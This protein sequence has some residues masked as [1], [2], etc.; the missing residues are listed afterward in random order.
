MVSRSPVD[1]SAIRES[2][3]A[4]VSRLGARLIEVSRSIQ[5]T[6]ADEIEEL[7]G[8]GQVFELLGAA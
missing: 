1:D 5:Q 4:I 2:A 7:R 8:D 3:A 6:L